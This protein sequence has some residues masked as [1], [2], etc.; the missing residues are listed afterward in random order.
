MADPIDDKLRA[1]HKAYWRANLK[2]LAALLGVWFFSS[3]VLGIMMA[4]QLNN[5]KVPGT[6]FPV[7][8]WFAQQGSI[9]IFVALI[10]I[11]TKL[12]DQLDA[13]FDVAE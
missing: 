13:R 4:D 11:Y 6:E 9:Y 7:G 1:K 12:M 2:I 5:Y 8:F 10:V 3:Y